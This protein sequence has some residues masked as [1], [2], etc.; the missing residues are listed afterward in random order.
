MVFL[1]SWQAEG[2]NWLTLNQCFN[3]FSLIAPEHIDPIA[4]AKFNLIVWCTFSHSI[5]L[6]HNRYCNRCIQI[7]NN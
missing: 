5:L 3:D 6:S 7:L 4:L 2:T 1:T